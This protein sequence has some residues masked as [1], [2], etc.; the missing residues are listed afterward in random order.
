M[1][2]LRS[3][4]RNLFPPLT[5]LDLHEVSWVHASLRRVR[6]GPCI[7]ATTRNSQHD[8]PLVQPNLAGLEG[9]LLQWERNALEYWNVI[10]EKHPLIRVAPVNRYP[11][12]HHRL[13]P[14]IHSRYFRSSHP[15]PHRSCAKSFEFA[16]MPR[17]CTLGSPNCTRR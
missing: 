3:F 15:N 2:F 12:H 1:F 6:D 13:M 7:Y 10:L 5:V 9:C 14:G 17:A 11:C 4:L 8:S 16:V